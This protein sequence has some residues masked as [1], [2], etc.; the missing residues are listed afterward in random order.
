MCFVPSLDSGSSRLPVATSEISVKDSIH[1]S[2]GELFNPFFWK[3]W[4]S[5]MSFGIVQMLDDVVLFIVSIDS[6][7][8][9]SLVSLW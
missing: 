2:P 9:R 7:Y 4:C 6:P 1:S 5:L 3:L 8:P